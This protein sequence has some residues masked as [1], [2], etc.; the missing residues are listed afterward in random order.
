MTA[1]V[2]GPDNLFGS[3]T[4]TTPTVSTCPAP[5]SLFARRLGLWPGRFRGATTASGGAIAGSEKIASPGATATATAAP[6]TAR[7]VRRL[8]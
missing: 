2:K 5:G 3:Q 7:S 8:S 6:Q 4:I 1:M